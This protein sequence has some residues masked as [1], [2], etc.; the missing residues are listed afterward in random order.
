MA[1]PEVGTAETAASGLRRFG[2]TMMFAGGLHIVRPDGIVLGS[3]GSVMLRELVLFRSD[4][5]RTQWYR[6]GKMP[7]VV[8]LPDHIAMR[9]LPSE[10]WQANPGIL[11][12]DPVT[13][14]DRYRSGSR[15]LIGTD[16]TT[17]KVIYRLWVSEK[18]VYTDWI[19]KLVA[20]LPGNLLVFDVWV[21]PD[22]RGGNVHWAGAS[23]ACQEAVRC[24]S[25]GIVGGVEENEYFLFAAKYA[26]L[27]LCLADPY[28]SIVGLKISGIKLHIQRKPS[29]RVTEFSHRLAKRFPA[30][31][32]DGP[33][34]K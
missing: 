26:R 22:Y 27:G 19:F 28:Q 7:L 9:W 34:L 25:P 14:G 4:L 24:G 5:T 11:S 31:V 32:L 20:P 33:A 12:I 18:G 30:L 13:A 29:P 10:E 6:N 23:M 8:D 2:N 1:G 3:S 17:G 21:D 15:C 16:T